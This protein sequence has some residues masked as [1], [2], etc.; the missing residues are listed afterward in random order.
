MWSTASVELDKMKVEQ[1]YTNCLAEAAYYIES[2]GEVAIV[3]PLREV[4]QYVDM[5]ERNGAK[6]K[7]IFE[8]HFH[9]D[10]VSG[11]LDLANSTGAEIVFGPS[12]E[13]GFDATIAE[14]GQEFSIGDATLKVLHTPGHTLE[15]STYLLKDPAGKDYCIFTGDTLFIG[16]VGRP[17][18]AIKSELTQEDLA[19]M[20]YDSLRNKI[21]PLA[22]DVIVYPAH[23]AGSACG[24]NMS[25]E[26]Y[27]TL[28]DQKKN[29][30][31]LQDISKEDFILELTT[32]IMPPPAYF[33]KAALLNKNGYGNINE[34]VS[35]GTTRLSPQEALDHQRIG[36]LIL[37]TRS[38]EEFHKGFIKDSIFIGIDGGFAPWVGT[39]LLDH[40]QP[41]VI[42][43][44]PGRE[45]EVATRLA[46]VGFD[47][48]IGYIDGGYQA[49]K[50]SGLETDLIQSLS[51]E[52]VKRL[53][54][55][56]EINLI[57]SRKP[58]EFESKRAKIAKNNPLD[59]IHDQLDRYNKDETY[60]VHCRSGYRSLIYTSILKKNG[61]N[62]VVDVDGGFVAM[63]NTEMEMLDFSCS[64]GN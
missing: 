13:T 3:D 61:I 28:G 64:A 17:D 36:A 21:L 30:Y 11:H 59:F 39:V 2:N 31:A 54:E 8:T 38:K 51:A 29:N 19:G 1:I 4:Q 53:S 12:A 50:D 6:I 37:D 45:E 44:E 22:D 32:G 14:D 24:K 57:D 43:S 56:A 27:A 62:D 40:K 46:R 35:S 52:E 15:S 55:S 5:A 42:L 20:L 25:S 9:A 48:S 33:P 34:V 7:Y 58:S 10:F 60:Y 47:N 18:L 16:D 63:E 41:I 23:G 49:W 26:T